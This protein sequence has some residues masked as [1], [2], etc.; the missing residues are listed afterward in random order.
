VGGTRIHVQ[1]GG[2]P[3]FD[4][5]R[6]DHRFHRQ[7]E[8]HRTTLCVS[9]PAT[10]EGCNLARVPNATPTISPTHHETTRN[11]TQHPE[12]GS[13]LFC[14]DFSMILVTQFV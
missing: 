7:L 12:T 14:W 9:G 2:I 10:N 13:P 6:R 5:L 8:L 4:R 3:F 11:D 1:Q